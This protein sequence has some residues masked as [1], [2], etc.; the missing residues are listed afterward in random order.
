M[1]EVCSLELTRVDRTSHTVWGTNCAKWKFLATKRAKYK[2]TASRET[3]D[4]HSF[5]ISVSSAFLN[6]SQQC[7]HYSTFPP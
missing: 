5:L 1:G 7:S 4:N 6:G 3:F 2:R